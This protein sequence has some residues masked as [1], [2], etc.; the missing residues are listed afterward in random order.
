MS[1]NNARIESDKKEAQMKYYT[2]Q[3]KYTC[4][5]DL[6]AKIL[7]VC[8]LDSNGNIV[9]H[10]KCKANPE[11]LLQLIQPYLEDLLIGVE[12]MFS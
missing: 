10:K 4:G 2:K 8:V 1:S 3:H 12:C 6:H 11:A 9:V 7:Y 5:I